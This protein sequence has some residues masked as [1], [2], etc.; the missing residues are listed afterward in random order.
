MLMLM[1]L[2]GALAW[3]YPFQMVLIYQGTEIVVPSIVV[4]VVFWG[5]YAV[6]DVCLYASSMVRSVRSTWHH[7]WKRRA[8]VSHSQQCLRMCKDLIE[9]PGHRSEEEI[10]RCRPVTRELSWAWASILV[11]T[12]EASYAN[13]AYERLRKHG[14]GEARSWLVS[15]YIGLQ[16]HD[17]AY[18]LMKDVMFKGKMPDYMKTC[19]PSRRVLAGCALPEILPHRSWHNFLKRLVMAHILQSD[20]VAQIKSCL[21]SV[22]SQWRSEKGMYWACLERI[23]VLSLE[24]TQEAAEVIRNGD[25][26]LASLYREL[27]S[28]DLL[29]LSQLSAV[30]SKFEEVGVKWQSVLVPGMDVKSMVLMIGSWE[31]SSG[32][33]A[34]YVRPLLTGGLTVLLQGRAID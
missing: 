1:T 2:S 10:K 32:I 15:A 21:Q 7:W 13:V 31:E 19:M 9:R 26:S 5:A 18:L 16:M 20:H 3:F 6:I 28:G 30:A 25:A 24:N 34:G 27:Y 11:L 4:V 8:D 23:H 14:A 17:A 12:K 33:S 29:H 22:P